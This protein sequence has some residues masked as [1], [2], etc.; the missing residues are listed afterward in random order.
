MTPYTD[1]TTEVLAAEAAVTAG[2]LDTG[3]TLA[4][5][6]GATL[7]VVL[8]LGLFERPERLLAWVL[9]IALSLAQG[10]FAWRVRFDAGIFRGWSRRWLA[11]AEPA[12]DMAA[13]DRVL[14]RPAQQSTAVAPTG[15]LARRRRGALRLLFAQ[16]LS[17]LAQLIATAIALGG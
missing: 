8:A 1:R 7:F 15:D 10:V 4:G 14:G 3:A 6:S 16:A 12:A 17:L 13:F 2:L 5:I 9:A 11:S